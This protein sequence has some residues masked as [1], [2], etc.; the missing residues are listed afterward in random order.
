MTTA[1]D[2]GDEISKIFDA[3]LQFLEDFSLQGA[4]Q[5]DTLFF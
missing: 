5:E 2:Y 3:F 1:N 4:N